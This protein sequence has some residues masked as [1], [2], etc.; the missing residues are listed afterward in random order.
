[1]IVGTVF[2]VLMQLENMIFEVYLELS[3]IFFVGF[4]F[5]K[6]RPSVEQVFQRNYFLEH[7]YGK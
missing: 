2:Q 6:F 7:S 1:M 3:H 4:F 5:F